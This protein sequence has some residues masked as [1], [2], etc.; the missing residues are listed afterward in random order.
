M[1]H[2]GVDRERTITFPSESVLHALMIS[3]PPHAY[4]SKQCGLLRS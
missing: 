1:G 3:A 4:S 2:I